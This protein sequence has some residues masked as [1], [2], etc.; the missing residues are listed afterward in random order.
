MRQP[1]TRQPKQK[2]IAKRRRQAIARDLAKIDH[3]EFV[4]AKQNNANEEM[5]CLVDGRL[6]T[7]DEWVCSSDYFGNLEWH[8]TQA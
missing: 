7:S 1:R 2:W 6:P 4:K 5:R 3:R 8:L